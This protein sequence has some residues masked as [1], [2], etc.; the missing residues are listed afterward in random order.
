[1][2]IDFK[3][4]I[5]NRQKSSCWYV[6][7]KCL[8]NINSSSKVGSKVF[9]VVLWRRRCH[10][11]HPQLHGGQCCAMHSVAQ[12]VAAVQLLIELWVAGNAWSIRQEAVNWC[13]PFAQQRAQGACGPAG[14]P[15]T[16]R[17]S[18]SQSHLKDPRLPCIGWVCRNAGL[19]L[20]V[21]LPH[22]ASSSC[23]CITVPGRGLGTCFGELL[24]VSVD[25]FLQFV[26][27]TA[28]RQPNHH[29]YWPLLFHFSGHS[30]RIPFTSCSFA[31]GCS[32]TVLTACWRKRH[33][34]TALSWKE[35]YACADLHMYMLV[36]THT[37]P[38]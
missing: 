19:P 14:W 11:P 22:R 21:V 35:I 27:T 28:E 9:P 30:M 24:E 3:D 6:V 18:R 29:A 32:H 31:G 12:R 1:M 38:S 23:F 34:S 4:G 13:Q 8:R 5:K 17:L 2:C 25:L 10:A 26:R 15:D 7:T 16:Q 36:H 37:Q 33:H 20:F